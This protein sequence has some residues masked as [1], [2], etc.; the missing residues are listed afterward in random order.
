MRNTKLTKIISV[1][2]I[3][4]LLL[5]QAAPARAIYSPRLGQETAKIKQDIFGSRQL[6]GTGSAWD[7]YDRILQASKKAK[8]RGESYGL[9]GTYQAYK[10][11]IGGLVF[12]N[13][14]AAMGDDFKLLIGP[15]FDS[16]LTACRR[17]DIWELQ[18][19]QEEVL[20]ELWKASLSNDLNYSEVLFQDYI[21][22]TARI[23]GGEK[24]G[25][26]KPILG[27]WTDWKN[28]AE[29]FPGSEQNLYVDCN[30]GDIIQAWH[31]LVK[32]I[33]Q[34]G[35][36]FTGDTMLFGSL[37]EM[38]KVAERRAVAKAAAY[39]A[40][41]KISISFGGGSGS[42]PIGLINN[43]RLDVLGDNLSLLWDQNQGFYISSSLVDQA[44]EYVS[45]F[46]EAVSKQTT[47]NMNIDDIV[48]T[49]EA[50]ED[51]RRLQIDRIEQALTYHLQLNYVGDNSLKE[52]NGVLTGINSEIENAYS[53]AIKG[54]SVK[55]L[56]KQL[57][58]VLDKHC[59]N[60][61]ASLDVSCDK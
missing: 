16:N 42:A 4:I 27:L 56:C 46:A 32:S 60:K 59:S 31:E 3:V 50:I 51:S 25:S 52:L 34:L 58:M 55:D 14:L 5:V 6:Y 26:G 24:D 23:R 7:L 37:D 43:H 41:N 28:T 18:A 33:G 61:T 13:S 38:A 8:A 53:K 1:S 10:N 35:N 40:K 30:Y 20:N 36:T 47:A 21:L 57:K 29:W 17:D 54:G 22:L 45:S 12:L 39:I 44:K 9:P 2:L 15:I 11:N 48:K 19:L 49:Y